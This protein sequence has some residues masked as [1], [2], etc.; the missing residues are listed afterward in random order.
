MKNLLLTV[1]PRRT[2]ACR[3]GGSGPLTY[4]ETVTIG[5]GRKPSFTRYRKRDVGVN[6][7]WSDQPVLEWNLVGEST[8]A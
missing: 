3:D 6:L 5:N 2:G 1:P 4:G 7:D 8:I